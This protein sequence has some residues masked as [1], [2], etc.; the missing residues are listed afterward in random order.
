MSDLTFHALRLLRSLNLSKKT[1][2]V[3]SQFRSAGANAKTESA[4][5]EP[6]TTKLAPSQYRCS[7][8]SKDCGR[9]AQ[10][11]KRC[12]EDYAK[13]LELIGWG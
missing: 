7:Y 4:P 9:D 8:G 13:F 11:C 2:L 6:E 3:S 12:N 1:R 10:Y 5:E